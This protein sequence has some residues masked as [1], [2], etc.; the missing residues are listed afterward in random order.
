[1]FLINMIQ[2]GPESHGRNLISGRREE[3]QNEKQN[4]KIETEQNRSDREE[5]KSPKDQLPFIPGICQMT[6]KESSDNNGQIEHHESPAQG[7]ALL[8]AGDENGNN[9]PNQA[10]KNRTTQPQEKEKGAHRIELPHGF[11][12]VVQKVSTN[13]KCLMRNLFFFMHGCRIERRM[14]KKNQADQKR[15]YEKRAHGRRR[16]VNNKSKKCHARNHATRFH[17]IFKRDKFTGKF[18]FRFR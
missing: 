15:H 7:S 18:F 8:R 16:K 10:V 17:H 14:G 1:M 9:K 2:P 11:D 12:D 5:K 6:D 13:I 3:S 4:P